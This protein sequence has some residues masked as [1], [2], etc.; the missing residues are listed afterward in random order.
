MP[1]MLGSVFIITATAKPGVSTETLET[2]IASEL[3]ELRSN[4]PTREELAT[5]RNRI[6]TSLV[7]SLEEPGGFSG[8]ADRLNTYNHY[9]GN[10][11]YVAKDFARYEAI[12]R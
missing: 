6:Q 4:G 7:F 11:A 12:T 8:V 3:E 2:S 10:P 1:L 5:A 9:L